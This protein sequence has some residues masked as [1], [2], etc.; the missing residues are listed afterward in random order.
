MFLTIKGLWSDGN[1][2]EYIAIKTRAHL[3]KI[4]IWKNTFYS[5]NFNQKAFNKQKQSY[6][7]AIFRYVMY[8]HNN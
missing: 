8:V 4:W 2:R 5:K 7:F 1:I 3:Y 6:G